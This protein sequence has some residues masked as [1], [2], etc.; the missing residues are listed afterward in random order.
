MQYVTLLHHDFGE[1]WGEVGE[2]LEGVLWYGMDGMVASRVEAA[3]CDDWGGGELRKSECLP[4]Q[5]KQKEVL[6]RAPQIVFCRIKKRSNQCPHFPVEHLSY[7][8]SRLVSL[9][10][11]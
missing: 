3:I 8:A 9:V 5:T 10:E 4:P 11:L 1:S 6:H 2:K 7:S